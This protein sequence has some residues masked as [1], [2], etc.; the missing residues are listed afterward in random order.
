M[1]T[2]TRACSVPAVL[3]ASTRQV[4]QVLQE[5][6]RRTPLLVGVFKDQPADEATHTPSSR[7]SCPTARNLPPEEAYVEQV[8]A[9]VARHGLDLV[10]LHGAEDVA[11]YKDI[12]G[13]PCIKALPCQDALQGERGVPACLPPRGEGVRICAGIAQ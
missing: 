9:T 8:Q 2:D 13:V 3:L 10:Q 1:C 12:V 7:R 4:G 6:C 5:G 11:A